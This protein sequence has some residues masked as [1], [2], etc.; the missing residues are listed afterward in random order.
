MN[1]KEIRS[2]YPRNLSSIRN[3]LDGWIVETCGEV[4]AH[5]E[6]FPYFEFQ[7]AELSYPVSDTKYAVIG[8]CITSIAS[9]L[10]ASVSATLLL[11]AGG[12]LGA[13]LH[14]GPI[15]YDDD[16]DVVLPVQDMDPFLAKCESLNIPISCHVAGNA[17]KMYI[18]MP[19]AKHA[20][21]R[22]VPWTSP[23]V[24]IFLYT[25]VDDHIV[26]TTPHG[27]KKPHK[28]ELD[29]FFPLQV[30][31]F[32]GIYLHGPNERV[33]YNRYDLQKC[34][35]GRYNHR[36]ELPI[37]VIGQDGRVSDDLDCCELRRHLPF[38]YGTA[39]KSGAAH[40]LLRNFS[41]VESTREILHPARRS[42]LQAQSKVMGQRLSNE[43]PH[44][45]QVEIDNS[46]SIGCQNGKQL[47]V[48]KFNMDR[49]GRWLE[50]TTLLES[51]SADV[52]ILNEMDYGMARTGQQHTTRLLAQNLR[53]NYAWGV[54]FV[55]LTRGTLL[56]Q[57]KTSNMTDF[58]SLHGN[59]VLTRCHIRSAK[60]FR[61][62]VGE[63]FGSEPSG[64]NAQGYENRLGGRMALVAELVVGRSINVIVMSTHKVGSG[65]VLG[66][67]SSYRRRK[68]ILGGDQSQALCDILGLVSITSNN[69]WP[70]S[71]ATLGKSIGDRICTNLHAV[72]DVTTT[73]MPCVR[74]PSADIQLSDHAILN[75]TLDVEMSLH[76]GEQ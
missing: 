21:A 2:W 68:I 34:K 27:T 47:Q 75:T 65:K 73:R 39:I 26:E 53:M 72:L 56:E 67:L 32:G 35:L 10:A 57:S 5:F 70:A 4:V 20:S 22:R 19:E 74:T 48:V 41:E 16:I 46:Q 18:D 42:K 1:M 23:Y 38:K 40:Q 51:I 8:T 33:A 55:E 59:A 3:Q 63:Y 6:K 7:A 43:I 31:Y 9:K 29:V 44:I 37:P 76:D 50:A 49:A 58:Q 52:I 54:E 30:Y 71:C 45:D 24:D 61:D 25:T 14:G 36:F 28:Y 66:K 64:L 17:I 69:T 15:P 11:Y 13:V 60:I 62:P 12:H